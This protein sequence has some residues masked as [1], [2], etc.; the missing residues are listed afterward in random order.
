MYV[1]T[2]DPQRVIKAFRERR[3]ALRNRYGDASYRSAREWFA[4]LGKTV[5]L[6]DDA[7]TGEPILSVEGSE[8]GAIITPWI[9][10]PWRLV[11][12]PA[13]VLYHDVRDADPRV[14]DYW[15]VVL[16]DGM[17]LQLIRANAAGDAYESACTWR[18]L[19]DRLAADTLNA[20]ATTD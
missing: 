7:F 11:L 19:L 2:S 17:E 1:A 13:I 4:R 10:R 6:A 3:R 5:H 18:E 16:P 9:G 12:G 20:V 15:D 8:A 14:V